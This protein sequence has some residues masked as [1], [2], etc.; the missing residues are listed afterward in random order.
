MS[1]MQQQPPVWPAQFHFKGR[2]D[3]KI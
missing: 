1:V 3:S 2:F